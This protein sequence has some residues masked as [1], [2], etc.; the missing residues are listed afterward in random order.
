VAAV[1]EM[2]AEDAIHEFPP[3]WPTDRPTGFLQLGVQR[4][5]RERNGP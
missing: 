4:T 2:I 5:L 1:D 3:D